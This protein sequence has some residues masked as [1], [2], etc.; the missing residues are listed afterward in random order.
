[1]NFIRPL[2]VAAWAPLLMSLLCDI[3]D[4]QAYGL[5]SR[6]AVGANF[7]NIFPS[8][9]PGIPSDW[10]T[11]LAFPN[12]TF[13]NPV[14]LA[15]VPG[16][17]KLLVWERE[18]KLWIFDNVPATATKTLVVDLSAHCQGWDDSGLLGVAPHPD[19][20]TN[21]Q[22]YVWYNWRGGVPGGIG[23]NGP[24]LGNQNTRPETIS[25]TRNRLSRFTLNA[26]YQA[27][28]ANEY[29]IIDQKTTSLWHNGGGMFFHP[30]NGFLYL[31]NGDDL[32]RTNK[33]QNIDG[34]LFS[35]VMRLDLD[36]R[37]GS[38]SHAPTRR[39]V[40]EVSPG[41]PRYF[42][43][44]DN[45]FVGQP[46]A[47]EE[48]FA[49]GFRSPHRMTLDAVT[50]RI[51]IGDVGSDAFEEVSIIE[52][53]DPPGLNFQW[54]RIEGRHGD[55]TAPYIGVNKRPVIDY[56]HATEDGSCVVGGYVYRGSA[57]PELVGKYIFG[58]NI[59]GRIW[60][61]DESTVPATKVLLATLPDGPGPNS[62]NDYRGLSSFGQDAANEL[63]ICQ[64]SFTAGRIY[65]LQRGG[66]AP[67]TP[68]PA[69]LG[70]TGL[71]TNLAALT[72]SPKLIPYDLNEPFWSDGASKKR[73]AAIPTGSSI[74]FQASGDWTF[75]TGS[76][77]V[78]HFDLPVN[79]ADPAQKRRLETRF[80]VKKA[81][82]SVYGATYKWRAD[83]SDAD[84]LDG[85]LTESIPI[86]TA[87]L[88]TLTG[89][90]I[91]GPSLAGSTVRA[92]NLVTLTAG[93]ADI[94]NAAD[95]LHYAHQLRSGDFD[96]AVKVESV[97]QSDLYTKA[98]L[99]VRESLAADARNVMA[100]VFA[101]NAER[102]DNNGGY[103]MQHRPVA[104]GNSFA[105]FPEAPQPQVNYPDTWLRMKRE[106]NTFIAYNGSDGATWHEYART[107]L[108]LPAQ[109]YF[110]LAATA[111]AATPK[112]TVKFL[113]ETRR[114]QWY[115]PGRQDCVTCHTTQSGGALGLSARQF[116]R[117]LL[118]SSTGVTDNQLR[119]WNHVGLFDK[120]PAEVDIP[121]I[122]KLVQH[123]DTTAPLDK[124]ARSYLDANCSS[125]HRPGGAQAFWDAR[126]QTP[127]SEQGIYYG[128]VSNHLGNPDTRVVVPQSLANSIM[129]RRLNT[130]GANQMP[131]IA[132]N[133]VDHAGVAV[134]AEWIASLQP[135]VILP[136][137]TLAGAAVSHTRVNLTWQD[138]STNELG[139]YIE[140]S[141][142]GIAFTRIGTTGPSVTSFSDLTAEP[143]TTNHYRVTAFATFSNS[144]YT[145]VVV[146]VTNAGPPAAEIRI[147]GNGHVISNNDL[148]PDTADG[149]DF[150][151]GSGPLTRTFTLENPGNAVLLLGGTPRIRIDGAGASSYAVLVQPAASI[152]GAGST[153]FQIRFLPQGTGIKPA[154]IVIESNDPD[155]AVTSFAVTGTGIAQDLVGWWKFDEVSGL[156][157]ADSSGVGNNG[158]LSVPLPTWRPAGRL[159]GALRFAGLEG[160]GVTIPNQ[161]ILS[162][163]AALTVSAWIF[164]LDWN[165]NRRIIQKGSTDNQYRLTSEEGFLVWDIAG[166]GY[167][168]AALPP[169]NTWSHVAATF[170]GTIMRLYVN[171]VQVASGGNAGP[172]PVT[173]D[174]L[175]LG[176]KIAA[177]P[178]NDHF[179][180]DLDDVRLYSRALPLAEIATLAAQ[181]GAVSITAADGAAQKGTA[182]SGSFLV[183]RTGP[184]AQS[185]PVTLQLVAG[186][187]E[188]VAAVDFTLSPALAGFAIP[189]GQASATL[190]LTP[191]ERTQ[192][193]GPLAATLTVSEAA[194]YAAGASPV[195]QVVIQDSPLNQWKIT[196]FGSLAAAQSPA[197]ADTADADRDHLTVLMEAA[198]GGSPLLNDSQR[199]PSGKLEL[200]GGQ[201][202]LTST[203]MR[204]KPTLAGLTYLHRS[205]LNPG[206][207]W[208]NATMVA[209]YPQDN[210]NGTETV[211]TRSASTVTSQPKQFMRLEVTRP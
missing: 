104:G 43:P 146:A 208:S 86:A 22:I 50:G 24:I 12:L 82:G 171:G 184:T 100:L 166:L 88:G 31:T 191:F 93:G 193:T 73:F 96:V 206:G 77:F 156:A 98:G 113:V 99:M 139:F 67:G 165:G 47:L 152:P 17:N 172:L 27:N 157:A 20:A 51:F 55:L 123:G 79:D 148:N 56:P 39:A 134:L 118:Y 58:D 76:V 48:M 207:G 95:Q 204:P 190:T 46:N 174:P 44:N 138:H 97:S 131:P 126:Y 32:D 186:V 19:F 103:Q 210:L 78:K 38:I 180:G 84:L 163:P 199:L 83:Q 1:M 102:V 182:N 179:S 7:D 72:P 2:Q 175:T 3:A 130:V 154:V 91:G 170:N 61:L 117:D 132:R 63:Y 64:M 74:G 14:G 16:T 8:E 205:S 167:L 81:D 35:C 127:F 181:K 15:P 135:E 201:L 124:R 187:G 122:E 125:C 177:A 37:G 188:A 110:G 42:V 26:S 9:P 36:Q 136:P 94:W 150:G 211:K 128:P 137:D 173:T 202:Y 28:A 41:W 80:L 49:I 111:H 133:L 87:P 153:T 52:P 129:H 85:S 145:N 92:G 119:A 62:G 114:Q 121:M 197:A 109:V 66:A 23:E 21:R 176:A 209:G 45:P 160:E 200:I 169:V 108:A 57:F 6:P 149:T 11:V 183:T 140:R 141:A 5:A 115:Y 4:A 89:Q 69:T 178:D 106:G 65:K 29:I 185:L 40:D 155:E 120:G 164:P 168:Q 194:G 101:S 53:N 151:L 70:A 158:A 60:Y 203:Y 161:A 143:F 192:V 75:P 59:S 54:G 30:Q 71:F 10:S 159:G 189:A 107:T 25:P 112:T 18:G 144:A 33:S 147:S 105:I 142:D 195:A 162:P 34:G 68:L 13:S 116:N 90:D 196:A 198:L